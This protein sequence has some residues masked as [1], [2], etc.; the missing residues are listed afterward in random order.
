MDIYNIF[1]QQANFFI[2]VMGP[3]ILNEHLRSGLCCVRG[4]QPAAAAAFDEIK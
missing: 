4:E 2:S 3:L 1:L